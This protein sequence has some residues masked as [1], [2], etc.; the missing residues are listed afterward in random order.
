MS[1]LPVILYEDNQ[2][3]QEAIELVKNPNYHAR[4]KHIDIRYHFIREH[5]ALNDIEL[6]YLSTE[7]MVADCLTK[8]VSSN[9]MK[10]FCNT[11]FGL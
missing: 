8:L 3:N 1:L 11:L 7:L 2:L 5:Y 6:C 4:T 9:N 10:I